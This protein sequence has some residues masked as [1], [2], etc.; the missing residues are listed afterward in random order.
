[1]ICRLSYQLAAFSKTELGAFSGR[2][3][4][5]TKLFET[6]R[7]GPELAQLY[8]P[9]ILSVWP[10][11]LQEEP[12]FHFFVL[13]ARLPPS[14]HLSTCQ[15][16]PRQRHAVEAAL[17]HHPLAEVRLY[18]AHVTIEV[19]AATADDPFG[20]GKAPREGGRRVPL[21]DTED[22]DV[23]RSLGYR[24]TIVDDAAAT[25]ELAGV[26]ASIAGE[27]QGVRRSAKAWIE[28][29][30]LWREEE[31]LLLKLL[32]LYRDGGV[33][34]DLDV[35]ATENIKLSGDYLFNPFDLNDG[36]PWLAGLHAPTIMALHQGSR[37]ARVHYCR[38]LFEFRFEFVLI[39]SIGVY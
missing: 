4:R 30:D 1:M 25:A 21:L 24:V 5:L 2:A 28:E 38:I 23:M 7:S 39:R 6:A 17:M 11:D 35:Y 10:E 36:H 18:I 14:H 3:R 32:V 12:I 29:S 13:P 37:F 16:S 26:L 27:D 20:H 34:L 31:D 8:S 33:V 19:P 22:I 15:L 9:D